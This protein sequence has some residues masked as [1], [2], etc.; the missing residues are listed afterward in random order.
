MPQH[1]APEAPPVD[2]A[3]PAAI[4]VQLLEPLLRQLVE[5]IGLPATMALVEAHGGTR[6]CIA[7]KA[8]EN[9]ALVALVGPENA[10]L[11]G[12]H[13]GRERPVI[14]KGEAALR[15]LRNRRIVADLECMSVRQVALKYGLHERRIWQIQAEC[16]EAQSSATGSLFD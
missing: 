8:D 10:A 13:F 9:A 15:A 7:E 4:D 12:R 5:L 16:G 14:P 2:Q 6:L 3:A 11:L 1:S